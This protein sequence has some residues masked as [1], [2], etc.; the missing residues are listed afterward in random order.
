MRID[1]DVRLSPGDE[2]FTVFFLLQLWR[3]V[4]VWCFDS[5]VFIFDVDL[6]T[7]GAVAAVVAAL[8]ST[9]A[10]DDKSEDELA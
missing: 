4:P 3:H 7:F 2:I 1:F 8:V 5:Q 6:D 10:T 9:V